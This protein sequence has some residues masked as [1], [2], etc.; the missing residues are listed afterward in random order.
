MAALAGNLYFS[1]AGILA[2][3]TAVLL[4]MRYIAIAR[5]VGTL[6]LFRVHVLL[7]ASESVVL[8]SEVEWRSPA[9]CPLLARALPSGCPLKLRRVD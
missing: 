3:V 1:R 9:I 4:A 5:L 7:L 8:D 6:V 2:P